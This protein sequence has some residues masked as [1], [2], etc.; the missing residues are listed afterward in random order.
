MSPLISIVIPFYNSQD[1]INDCLNAVFK[2]SY[3]NFEVIA[4]SDG[5]KDESLKIA[6]KFPCKLIKSKKNYGSGHARN[7]GAKLAR[8]KIIVFLDSD[9]I[10]KKNHLKIIF[11][12][13]I[14]KN[15]KMAQGIYTHKP[16]YKKIS[17]Q[18]LQSYQCFYVFS[19]KLKYINN[20]VSN[21]FVIKKKIFFEV[22]GFDSKFI[23]SN[24]EDA[25]LGYKLTKKGYK[26]PILRN[27]NVLHKVNFGLWTFV[28][29]IKRIHTGEM[30]MFI[31]NKNIYRK[32]SQNNYKPIILSI[33]FL[34]VQIFFLIAKIFIEFQFFLEFLLILNSIFL[35]SQISFLKFL[36]KTRG[37]KVTIQCI[38]FMYLHIFLFIYSFFVGLFEY[39][40]FGK[41]Y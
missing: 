17:T 32:V 23:G 25:D 8:G 41:K 5:S 13:F 16:I 19:K 36:L 3:K 31:R 2:S 29:K 24:A 1:S 28:N 11:N 18:Y 20:L 39:F 27:L 14:K 30:K 6:K 33:I 38:P 12:Y 7:K 22:G 9:V 4:V 21:F 10:I 37:F 15:Y 34:F 26:I 35:I 40:L